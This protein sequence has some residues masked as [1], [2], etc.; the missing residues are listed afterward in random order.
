MGSPPS[1]RTREVAEAALQGTDNDG[2]GRESSTL[3][4]PPS[5]TAE[6][7]PPSPA[8][9]PSPSAPSPHPASPTPHQSTPPP[10]PSLRPR[11]PAWSP[12]AFPVESRSSQT[13]SADRPE[14]CSCSPPSRTRP[15][16]ESSRPVGRAASYG[17]SSSRF[18][19]GGRGTGTPL[20]R[21]VPRNAPC[22]Q[23]VLRRL[24][25]RST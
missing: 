3:P 23:R 1:F 10:A 20:L 25:P 16:R 7:P 21:R 2:S 14:S 12:P 17:W 22:R 11:S 8:P 13:D 24:H 5:H 9:P 18:G 4:P 6:T 15:C 19:H